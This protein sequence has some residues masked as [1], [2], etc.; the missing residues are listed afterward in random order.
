MFQELRPAVLDFP[1][2]FIRPTLSL[3]PKVAPR[4]RALILLAD[5]DPDR[6]R[7]MTTILRRE[8]YRVSQARDG[9]EALLKAG[10]LVPSVIVMEL[11]LPRLDGWSAIRLLKVDQRT[12][13]IPIVAVT[14]YGPDDVAGHRAREA[15][16][17]VFL[18]KPLPMI[19]LLACVRRLADGFQQSCGVREQFD[20]V[21]RDE[22]MRDGS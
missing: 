22:P 12:R 8:N 20:V 4:P 7:L 2:V 13:D 11:C 3:P 16:C 19:R 1:D 6:Q 5:E 14:R 15:G 21:F 10:Q 17:D 9:V 18:E